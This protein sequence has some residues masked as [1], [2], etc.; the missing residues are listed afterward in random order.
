MKASLSSIEE[1]E[2]RGGI[3]ER[4]LLALGGL[5]ALLAGTCCLAPLLLVSVGVSGAWLGHFRLLEPYRP[6][7]LGIALVQLALAWRRIYRRAA[8]CAPGT[9]C[10][11]AQV[12]RG[13]R[14]GFWSAGT[15]PACMFPFP[16]ALPPFS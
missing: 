7:F 11:A 10:A 4:G 2:T 5:G 9:V 6:L 8:R 14:I 15:P 13:Y 1:R 3:A 12:R 16:Y